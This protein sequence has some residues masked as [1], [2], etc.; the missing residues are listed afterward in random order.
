MTDT[1]GSTPDNPIKLAQYRV[2]LYPKHGAT[3]NIYMEAPDVY[4]AQQ[5]TRRVYPD[6][7][8]LA[9]KPLIDLVEER[10]S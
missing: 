9:I 3:E 6:H 1:V 2:T 5:Y 8:I 4:T 7:R 10:V